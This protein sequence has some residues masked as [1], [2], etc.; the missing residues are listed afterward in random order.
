IIRGSLKIEIK[1]TAKALAHRQAPSSIDA[2]AERSMDHQLHAARFVKEPFKQQPLL[3]RHHA[4]GR[5]LCLDVR[6]QLLRGMGTEPASPNQI[7]NR[8]LAIRNISL[9]QS[10]QVAKKSLLC[11]FASLRE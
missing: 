6:Q 7:R 11:V 5:V 1:R 4:G 8:K 2:R 3:R 10:R 9:A